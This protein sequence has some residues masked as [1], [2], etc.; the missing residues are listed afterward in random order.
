MWLLLV[1][2]CLGSVVITRAGDSGTETAFHK[3]VVAPI[4][5]RQEKQLPSHL[6]TEEPP[7]LG[8]RN[9]GGNLRDNS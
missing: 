8:P 7:P 1:V 2:V 5:V 4:W 3:A 9:L 6:Q